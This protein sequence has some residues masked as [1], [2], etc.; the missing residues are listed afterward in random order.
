MVVQCFAEPHLAGHYSTRVVKTD[1]Q[2]KV[3][4]VPS[5]TAKGTHRHSEDLGLLLPLPGI[6][7]YISSDLQSLWSDLRSDL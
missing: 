7:T 1:F 2:K 6:R 5:A 3:S 4:D